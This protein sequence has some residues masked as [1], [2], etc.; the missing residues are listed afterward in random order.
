MTQ[1]EIKEGMLLG[2]NNLREY[3]KVLLVD[4]MLDDVKLVVMEDM[5]AHPPKKLIAHSKEY[6]ADK[7]HP[8]NGED[9]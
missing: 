4:V 3:Y 2:H 7:Y 8:Y 9:F 1:E 5:V 6:V